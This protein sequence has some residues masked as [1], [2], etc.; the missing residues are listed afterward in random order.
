MAASVES[1]RMIEEEG[2][3]IEAVMEERSLEMEIQL[4]V[5]RGSDGAATATMMRTEI[6]ETG[7][8]KMLR[9]VGA[10]ESL[11]SWPA[12]VGEESRGSRRTRKRY[13]GSVGLMCEE[14]D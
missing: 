2:R 1:G 11:C 8:K 7:I 13:A 10:V 3:L 5:G 9:E 4:D 14:G 12:A 6:M